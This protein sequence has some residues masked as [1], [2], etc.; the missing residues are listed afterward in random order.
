M[1]A[2]DKVFRAED[3]CG[4]YGQEIDEDLAWKVGHACGQFLR[5]LLSG[6]E[7][8]QS[9]TNRLVVG[10]DMR[11]HSEMLLSALIEGVTSSGTACIDI[12][13]ADT[14]MLYFAVNHL[15][16]CGGIQITASH[17]PIEYNGFKIC[18]LKARPVAGSSGL[19]E[20]QRLVDSLRRMPVGAS[21][22]PRQ[23]IDLWDEYRKHV[24]ALLRT[25]RRLKVV[26]DAANGMGG[27]AIS[28]IF[29]KADVE[30]VPL[31]FDIGGKF[32]HPPDPLV[33]ANLKM[34]KVAVREEK[35]NFGLCLDGDADCCVFVDEKARAVRGD[36][37]T[38]LLARH[39][40]EEN[41]GATVVY[42][43]RSSRVV[44][45]E[46]RA[47]GGV[48]RRQR[49]GYAYMRKAMADSHAV[50]GGGPAG[51]FFF[52]DNYNCDSGAIA[53]AAALTV[54]SSQSKPFSELIRPLKRYSYSGQIDFQVEDGGAKLKEI[55]EALSD[56]QIDYL[57]GVTCQYEDWW[58]NVRPAEDEPLLCLTLEAK[59][60]TLMRKKLKEIK[61]IIGKAVARK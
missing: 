11:P 15:G 34:T 12:G 14:P 29:E 25:P 54:I 47:A 55:A 39:F 24:W 21:M 48:P 1:S 18:G 30:I 26:V 61:G 22:A 2:S 31:N 49:A 9:S 50:F 57:D 51:H 33:E 23:R 59:D 40:A 13:A 20:I 4:L 58:C 32:A 44:G 17:N 19:K 46:I 27:A 5:S 28:K 3:V 7:R 16:T 41:P 43:L 38:A 56:A 52:R 60:Q 37:M 35:A 42:D 6:Y 10:R 53:L 8:G 36:L 45:E